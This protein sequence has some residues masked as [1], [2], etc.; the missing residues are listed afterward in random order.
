MPSY[1]ID[2]SGAGVQVRICQLRDDVDADFETIIAL[3]KQPEDVTD[4]Q[5][6]GERLPESDPEIGILSR[7]FNQVL[8]GVRDQG[9][10]IA[11]TRIDGIK[12]SVQRPVLQMLL[13]RE[14]VVMALCL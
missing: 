9:S 13:T 5:Q 14:W 6:D 8:T 7:L 1:G 11:V 10:E 4:Q 3:S 2:R 12:E